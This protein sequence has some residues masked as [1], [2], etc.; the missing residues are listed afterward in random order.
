MP[1]APTTV[2][3]GDML[4]VHATTQ[5]GYWISAVATRDHC[6]FLVSER[7]T[8]PPDVEGVKLFWG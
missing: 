1:D 4:D 8:D 7:P 5:L 2:L 6:L 3:A